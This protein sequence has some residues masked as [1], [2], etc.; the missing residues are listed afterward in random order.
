MFGSRWI[1]FS[2]SYRISVSVDEYESV[3]LVAT[4]F[5]MAAL[6]LYLQQ[7][8]HS[9][10]TRKICTRCLCKSSMAL[11]RQCRHWKDRHWN[12][13]WYWSSASDS[14]HSDLTSISD[15]SLSDELVAVLFFYVRRDFRERRFWRLHSETKSSIIVICR[16]RFPLC[17][18]NNNGSKKTRAMRARFSKTYRD[19]RRLNRKE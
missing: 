6:L 4:D 14:E 17:L 11:P 8:I 12:R 13:N 1:L 5:K 18:A 16:S 19:R 10:Q 2:K 3:L 15:L 7:L 9:Y